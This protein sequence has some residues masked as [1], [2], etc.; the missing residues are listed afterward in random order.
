LLTKLLLFHITLVTKGVV[1]WGWGLDKGIAYDVRQWL[2]LMHDTI[3]LARRLIADPFFLTAVSSLEPLTIETAAASAL[4]DGSYKWHAALA[5]A[6][7]L[8]R[9]SAAADAARRAN[10]SKIKEMSTVT[11]EVASK[12]I[13]IYF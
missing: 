3:F 5:A 12:I 6:V 1:V 10:S 13:C 4:V 2:N 9:I 11:Y 7:L 8:A